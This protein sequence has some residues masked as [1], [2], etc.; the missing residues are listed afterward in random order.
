VQNTVGEIAKD[1][2]HQQRKANAQQFSPECA[3]SVEKNERHQHKRGEE[4]EK[5]V[6][7]GERAERRAGIGEI[8]QVKKSRDH[9]APQIGGDVRCHKPFRELIKG[10][11]E[12]NDEYRMTNTE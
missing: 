10:V 5:R 6:I 9:G 7:V 11:E 3:A 8:N 4:Y 1:A 12:E 2:R